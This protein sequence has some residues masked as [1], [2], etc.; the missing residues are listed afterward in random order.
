MKNNIWQTF[1]LTCVLGLAVSALAQTEPVATPDA[2][3][4]PVVSE[5][6]EASPPPEVVDAIMGQAAPNG[7]ETNA[8]PTV[9]APVTNLPPVVL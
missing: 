2:T 4:A 1:A 6:T 7:T 5:P 9:A 3:G 8:A